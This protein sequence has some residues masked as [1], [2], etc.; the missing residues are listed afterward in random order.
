MQL[1][2]SAVADIE[3]LLSL[4]IIL[5]LF[6]CLVL[7]QP[8]VGLAC[9]IF[10]VLTRLHEYIPHS[11]KIRPSVAVGMMVVVGLFFYLLRNKEP[12]Y[13]GGSQCLL[14]GVFIFFC[15]ISLLMKGPGLYDL[16]GHLII[17]PLL[18]I[19]AAFFI[20]LNAVRSS[21]DFRIVLATL[22]WGGLTIALLTLIQSFVTG[23]LSDRMWAFESE[24]ELYARAGT[25]GI[26]PNGVAMD[27]TALLPLLFFL[28]KYDK[29]SILW[30]SFYRLSIF[31]FV[32]VTCLTYSRA[33]FVNLIVIFILIS[34]KRLSSQYVVGLAA[35]MIA[36][37]I[38]VPEAFWERITST[39]TTDTTGTGRLII[40]QAAVNMIKAN[41][42]TGVGFGQFGNSYGQYGGE[43]WKFIAS[44]NTYLGIAAETGLLNLAVFLGLFLVTF[45]NLRR[46][47]REGLQAA[48]T[49]T[50]EISDVLN[51]GLIIALISGLT[52]DVT[53]W[54][55]L[56][57]YVALTVVL[58]RIASPTFAAS[59]L[60]PA[61]YQRQGVHE[62]TK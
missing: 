20:T 58:K 24:G 55:L 27:L 53:G 40:W 38:V 39:V 57:I 28:F 12:L 25:M 61:T 19:F 46:L 42:L 32:L 6:F 8:V 60:L 9:F 30:R 37:L 49:W 10:L 16:S 31:L 7:R 59:G 1:T 48:N 33:G 26:N 54:I 50:A 51:A 56:Y 17:E 29:P 41:P 15:C 4:S 45:A 21:R 62:M 2:G 18:L 13:S 47:K 14:V 52:G 35:L 43:G 36:I 5:C 3:L 11:E 22:A 34:R 44:H 23:S